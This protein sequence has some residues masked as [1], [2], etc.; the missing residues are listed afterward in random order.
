MFSH[1]KE[2]KETYFEHMG[3]AISI[4]LRMIL[5]GIACFIHAFFPDIFVATASD[6]RK[7]IDQDMLERAER[8]K[9]S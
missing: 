8:K 9:Q 2:I 4:A 7:K 6:I 5:G 1:L 3:Q